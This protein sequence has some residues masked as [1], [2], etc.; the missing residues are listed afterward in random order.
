[1]ASAILKAD[2]DASIDSVEYSLPNKH[3]I[4]ISLDWAGVDNTKEQDAEVF[5]PSAHPR[6]VLGHL[7]LEMHACRLTLIPSFYL[8]PN[9]GL[10]KAKI[11]RNPEEKKTA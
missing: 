7:R 11:S 6:Y 9:S 8:S 5:L 2:T 1:M 10:I 3:Y 4:P